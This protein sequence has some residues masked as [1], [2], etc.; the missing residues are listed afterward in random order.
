[1]FP[2][3]SATLINSE[4]GATAL[5]AGVATVFAIGECVHGVVLGPLVADL[6]PPHLLGRYISVFSLMVTGGFAIGPA[7]GGAVLAYSPDAVWWGGA[8]V[9]GV[10]S[11]GFLLVGDRIPDKPLAATESKAPPGDPMPEAA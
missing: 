10:I 11:V 7:I 3:L 4:L 8:L 2:C 6:A 9:A 5:L 1:M